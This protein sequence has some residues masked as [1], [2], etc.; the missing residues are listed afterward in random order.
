[1]AV[2]ADDYERKMGGRAVAVDAVD[3]LL[4]HNARRSRSSAV[5]GQGASPDATTAPRVA[6]AAL[7]I[8]AAA[9]HTGTCSLMADEC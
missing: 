8:R 5:V 3:P 9:M 2:G 6:A 1:M 4:G 7:A